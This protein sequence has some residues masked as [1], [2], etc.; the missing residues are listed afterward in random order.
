MLFFIVFYGLDW[1]ATVPPTVT[2]C[3][4]FFGMEKSAVVYGWVFA[5]HMIGAG[6][7]AAYAGWI[8]ESNGDY[9]IAWLT[10]GLLCLAAAAS[11]SLLRRR[12]VA[13]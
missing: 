12:E 13:V 10:A 3:R 4:Q 11:M 5:S 2:L 6:A 1:V 7:G 8:R 9:A